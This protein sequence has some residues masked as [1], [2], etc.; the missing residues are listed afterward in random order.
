MG[1]CECGLLF[2]Y[3]FIAGVFC[4]IN[5][6]IADVVDLFLHLWNISCC[7][8]KNSLLILFFARLCVYLHYTFRHSRGIVIKSFANELNDK[9]ESTY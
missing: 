1:W 2:T 8:D 6:A 9:K 7:S 4:L 3:R 5:L